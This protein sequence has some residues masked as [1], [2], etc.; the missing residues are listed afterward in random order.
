MNDAFQ[1][2]PLRTVLVT[3]DEPLYLPEFFETFLELLDENTAPI[4]LVGAVI[5]ETQ[6]GSHVELG[7]K[8]FG[9]YGPRAFTRLGL[10]YGRARAREAAHRA[11]LRARPETV[12]QWLRS[13]GIG[14]WDV[15]DVNS[16][17]MLRRVR[18]AEI[19]VIAGVA[20]PQIF[21][22][23]LLDA[24]NYGCINSHSGPLPRYRGMMP[25]FWSLLHDE[26][27]LTVTIHE[28]NEEI[29]D[30]AILEQRSIP[31]TPSTTLD[32]GIRRTKRLSAEM[33]HDVLLELADEGELSTRTI[34]EDADSS[35]FSFPDP[36]AG[37]RFREKRGFF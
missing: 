16:S 15:D 2:R 27:E 23:D 5:L 33:M 1:N 11:G 6:G 17:E 30:G 35:Y 18:D 37:R 10:E 22:S 32:T 7:K 4:D 31:V 26:P 8:L 21:E 19:D 29:D 34:P 20:P 28:M 25:V 36:D 9:V 14:I 13:G 12:P 24:P 3:Q